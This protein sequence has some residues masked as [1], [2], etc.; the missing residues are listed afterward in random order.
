MFQAV[1]KDSSRLTVDLSRVSADCC[2]VMDASR[3]QSR[4]GAKG[5]AMIPNTR[6][7]AAKR[8]RHGERQTRTRNTTAKPKKAPREKVKRTE[9]I[10]APKAILKM[11]LSHRLFSSRER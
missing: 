8:S 11:Y 10:E 3:S 2:S 1:S 9:T 7:A 6:T 5:A 4:C